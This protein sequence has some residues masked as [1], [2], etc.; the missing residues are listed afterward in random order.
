MR[1]LVYETAVADPDLEYN[2]E[3]TQDIWSLILQQPEIQTLLNMSDPDV[4]TVSTD[5]N[6][7]CQIFRLEWSLTDAD[8]IWFLL[9][10]P[11]AITGI[12][13]YVS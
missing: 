3:Y 12:P 8:M 1:K 10:Y 5:L 7:H 4:Q 13:Y 11:D 9:Q 6:R 2:S